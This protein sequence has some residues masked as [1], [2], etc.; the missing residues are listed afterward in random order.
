MQMPVSQPE[1]VDLAIM[2]VDWLHHGRMPSE[3][4]ACQHSL[5]VLLWM[6]GYFDVPLLVD[7][8]L[9]WLLA[10][11]QPCRRPA[12]ATLL[13]LCRDNPE[14]WLSASQFYQ[15]CKALAKAQLLALLQPCD[16]EV[17]Q[18]S[19]AGSQM[20]LT[21]PFDVL[22]EVL[23]SHETRVAAEST[24]AGLINTWLAAQHGPVS[25]EQKVALA[26]CLRLRGMPAYYLQQVLPQLQWWSEAM[27]PAALKAQCWLRVCK[28]AEEQQLGAFGSS[29]GNSTS[30]G[31]SSC[32][33]SS[34]YSSRSS[35]S[36]LTVRQVLER[37][38]KA[39]TG[40]EESNT[41]LLLLRDL[42][43]P[44]QMT[45][46]QLT[47]SL[48]PQQL[49]AVYAGR[50]EQGASRWQGLGHHTFGGLEWQ[51]CW[52]L[53]PGRWQKK[54]GLQ[55]QAGVVFS[56]ATAQG[57]TGVMVRLRLPVLHHRKAGVPGGSVLTRGQLQAEGCDPWRQLHVLLQGKVLSCNEVLPLQLSCEGVG[58]GEAQRRCLEPFLDSSGKLVLRVDGIARVH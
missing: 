9:Q 32:S 47:A 15:P 49:A 25:V 10:Q 38:L 27:G 53:A 45:Q 30:S 43:A 31:G 7:C 19:S 26:R 12:W 4:K 42:R 58:W 46:L 14:A 29:P 28:E 44:S 37:S 50:P 39:T 41:W 23:S 56:L 21:L 48:D 52:R 11:L 1:D 34:R 22:L 36:S 24:V 55:L 13:D 8:V 54:M 40:C 18:Q 17:L 35:S 20:L 2:M 16:L 3:V 5:L 51:L 33:D 57:L 6:G